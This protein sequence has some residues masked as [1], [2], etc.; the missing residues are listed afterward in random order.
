MKYIEIDISSTTS[1]ETLLIDAS[2]PK[3]EPIKVLEREDDFTNAIN[4][5]KNL[6]VQ[7]D[8]YFDS[9]ELTFGL[10]V[11]DDSYSSFNIYD[12]DLGD[13]NND[14][15]CGEGFP[16]DPDDCLVESI[17]NAVDDIKYFST[18]SLFFGNQYSLFNGDKFSFSI[19]SVMS[20]NYRDDFVY[21]M[22]YM[23]KR[24]QPYDL[25]FNYSRGFRIP[26]IKEL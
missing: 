18:H 9:N 16:W 6:L 12:Y 8:Y 11:T 5:N 24:F 26:A 23:L 13:N 4:Y 7:Y 20:K 17:F 22:A 25:R 2:N 21:S 3:G 14:G 15:Q 10:E 19:R 1:S